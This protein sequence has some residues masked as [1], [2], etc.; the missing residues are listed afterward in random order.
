MA[1]MAMNGDGA[2]NTVPPRRSEGVHWSL[3]LN[4]PTNFEKEYV[5][6]MATE[7]CVK[8]RIQMEVGES[9]TPHMQGYLHFPN[10]IRLSALK[11]WCERGHWEICRNPKATAEYC[12][13]QETATGESWEKGFPKPVKI[14]EESALRP[15]QVACVRI[16][17]SQPDDRKIYWYWGATGIGK[18][19][20]CKYLTVKYGAIALSGKCADMKNGIV[21]Y[22]QTNG[23]TPG[24]ILIPLPKTFNY[25]YISYDGIES[26]KDMYFYSGKYEGGMICGNCPH[27]LIFA[28]EPP[29]TSKLAHDRW[30]I[31]E[32]PAGSS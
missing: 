31:T 1:N 32:L 16:L 2:G 17:E 28:N 12:R 29:D 24:I 13:K 11:K 22:K 4:N 19:T 6:K 15:W 23:D 7:S 26:V 27:V 30:V 20:F 18:T 21:Q 3:T 25:D 14:L 8:F 9:G 10:K 5:P